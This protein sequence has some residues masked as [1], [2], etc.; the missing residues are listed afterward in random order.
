MTGSRL[1]GTGARFAVP[2][3]DA[4]AVRL[5]LFDRQGRETGRHAMTPGDDGWWRLDMAGIAAGQAY[6]FR[7]DGPWQ[8]DAGHWFDPDRLLVDPWATRIDRPYRHD[9]RLL[10][11]GRGAGGD[12]AGLMPKAILEPQAGDG[13]PPPVSLAPGGLVYEVNV[14]G[15][16]M[17]HPDIP[18]EERGTLSALKHPSVI[19]HLHSIGVTAVELMPVTAWIDERHLPSLGLANAWGYN[20]VTFM[21]LDPRLA[22]GGIGDLR[23]VSDA[24]RAAGIGV[25]LDLVF[26][27]TGESDEDGT[28]LSLRGLMGARAFRRDAQ[29]RLVNDTGTGNTVACDDP[30]IIGLILDSLRHFVLAGG[31][32]GFRFDLAPVLGRTAEGFS[33]DA[34]LL[35][36]MLDD[37]VTG[38]RV[39][40]AEPWD[41]GPGGYQLG[42]F[43][44]PFLEWN[45]A[46]RDDMRRF[47]RGDS[48]MLGR[49]ATR[50][51]GSQDVFGGHESRG[52]S[53]LAAHDGFTL[54]DLVSH[55][56]KHNEANGE[57]NRDG[58]D[59][60]ISWNNGTEGDSDDTGVRSARRADVTALLSTLYLTRG[61][62][63]LTAGDEFG[64][65]Q[66]GNNNAYAQD[67]ELTWIDWTNRDDRVLAHA[68]DLAR[69]RTR[70]PA[71]AA[72]AFLTGAATAAGIADVTW[73]RPD[74]A[75]MTPAD[76]EAEDG[77][78]LTM[79]LATGAQDEPL[80][81]VCVNR[82]H[83]DSTFQ[84]LVEE[85]PEVIASTRQ[86]VAARQIAVLV[87]NMEK[88]AWSLVAGGGIEPPTSGL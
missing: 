53:F 10:G 62:I 70:F 77:S 49:F 25:I 59:H 20:P 80:L 85:C 15:F 21:A 38:S 24:L 2:A 47:W 68:R 58:H 41:I 51:A 72:P 64:R 63:M 30:A 61:T 55:A 67:N 44:D 48:H 26:N 33:P 14:R 50:L 52:V 86:Q 82:S 65:S 84:L 60:N 66:R 11:R 1:T 18:A 29:G 32:D 69:L 28:I 36:A 56:H 13:V 76:W 8:P 37:P 5:C 78:Q 45:D 27:H 46:Y 7:A 42:R 40:I 4:T 79:L 87:L 39:L 23:A 81:A 75:A 6:G 35:Q 83:G 16:S 57:G 31:V 71:L 12:T 3:P 19:A 74:G 88:K 73:L 43:P 9:A 22:P 17:L 54:A 34:P